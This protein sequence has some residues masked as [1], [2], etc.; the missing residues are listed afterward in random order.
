MATDV[1]YNPG[2]DYDS[3]EYIID[4][5]DKFYICPQ[6]GGEYLAS[7]IYNEHGKIRCIDC[8]EDK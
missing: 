3:L 4:D 8:C 5:G 7:F 2:V 6:C 1:W